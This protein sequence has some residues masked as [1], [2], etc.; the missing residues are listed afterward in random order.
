V[1]D[2]NVATEPQREELA[3]AEL[4]RGNWIQVVDDKNN[5]LAVAAEVLHVETFDRERMAM[6]AYRPIG[7]EPEAIHI[8]ADLTMPLL[9]GDETAEAEQKAGRLKLAADLRALAELIGTLDLKLPGEAGMAIALPT[10]A[11]V[12]AVAEALGVETRPWVSTGLQA[13]WPKGHKSYE[14]GLHLLVYTSQEA[15]PEPTP[16]ASP[17]TGVM[18]YEK[19]GWKGDRP[20]SCGV[21]CNCG[22]AFDGFDDLV[23]A[24][25]HLQ[26]HIVD[27]EGLSY[28]RDDAGADDPT[29]VS[30][31]RVPLH[32]GG[33]TEDGLVDETEPKAG[34]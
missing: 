22:Q 28:T 34:S 9:T 7:G 21:E 14:D 19:R 13:T 17:A 11:A 16:T 27:P 29:P 25:V 33:M 8:G 24:Q 3:V 26:L 31:A 23:G 6:L 5:T 1:D 10:R 12:T 30:P 4:G 2:K 20:G 32:T 18:H 15:E